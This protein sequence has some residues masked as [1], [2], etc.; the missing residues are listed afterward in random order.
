MAVLLQLD[1][2]RFGAMCIENRAV[3]RSLF[4]RSQ[5]LPAVALEIDNKDLQSN[6]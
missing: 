2:S 6:E 1:P 4:T 5:L 3:G